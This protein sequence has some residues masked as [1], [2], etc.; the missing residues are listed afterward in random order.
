MASSLI[1]A[2]TVTHLP[3]TPRP[4]LSPT[5]NVVVWHLRSLRFRT[6]GIRAA[7]GIR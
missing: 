2:L 3:T 1:P 5:V 6:L 7:Y 4:R